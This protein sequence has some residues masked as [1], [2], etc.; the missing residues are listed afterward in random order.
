MMR[1]PCLLRMIAAGL[2][3]AMSAAPSMA[4]PD[5]W[6]AFLARYVD[7][8]DPS[9]VNRVRYAAV[10]PPDRAALEAHLRAQ[11]MAKP[12]SLPP[13]ARL[14]FWINLYN[15][16]TVAVVLDAYPVKSI[17]DIDLSEPGVK[18]PWK[19]VLLTVEGRGLSL[20]AIE[21]DILRPGFKDPRI[22]FALNCASLGCPGLQPV[23]FTAANADSLMDAAARAFVNSPRGAAFEDGVLQLSSLFEWY[24]DDFGKDE[25]AVLQYLARFARPDLAERLRKH[26]GRIEYRYDWSLNAAP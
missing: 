20:D 11:Q 1:L 2:A 18:G 22:H 8:S 17:L 5:P 7:A 15:A 4:G 14:A 16:R 3:L 21:N 19:A 13:K 9:K 24:R 23:P 10:T 26:R 25:K 6:A 12:S